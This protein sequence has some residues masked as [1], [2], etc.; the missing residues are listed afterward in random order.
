MELDDGA[1][2]AALSASLCEC[3]EVNIVAKIF[4]HLINNILQENKGD[5]SLEG[6]YTP[7]LQTM[8]TVIERFCGIFSTSEFSTLVEEYMS[9]DDRGTI[10]T[11]T[12]P[13]SRKRQDPTKRHAPTSRGVADPENIAAALYELIQLSRD[14]GGT[15]QVQLVGGANAVAVAAIGVWLVDLP[16]SF[17]KAGQGL[18]EVIHTTC[19][20]DQEPRVKV[21]FS[22]TVPDTV[23]LTKARVVYLYH[24]THILQTK[25]LNPDLV[26]GGRCKWENVFSGTFPGSFQRLMK[27]HSNFGP[28]LGSAARVF[29][30]LAEGDAE[31]PEDWHAACRTYFKSSFGLDYVA[32]ALW[33]FPELNKP[34]QMGESMRSYAELPSYSE[35]EREFEK[36]MTAIAEECH[37]KY[38]CFNGTP[39]A[40]RNGAP[41]TNFK[42]PKES[43]CLTALAS[44]IIRLVRVL[45]G[46]ELQHKSLYPTRAGVECFFNQ[47]KSRLMRQRGAA[48]ETKTVKDELFLYR[49][50]EYV[51]FT[52]IA[53]EYSPLAMAHMI[54][55]GRQLN[56]D[57]RPYSSAISSDGICC[58]YKILVEPSRDPAISAQV[59]V[60]PGWIQYRDVPYS[61]VGD[62]GWNPF[63]DVAP[64]KIENRP[65]FCV[66]EKTRRLAQSCLN[67]KLNL[68]INE[69]LVEERNPWLE[70]GF[71]V[72]GKE[73]LLSHLGPAKA[74]ENLTRGTGL[75]SCQGLQYHATDNVA[76]AIARLLPQGSPSEPFVEV[77][78]GNSNIF[79]FRGDLSTAL[80]VACGSWRPLFLTE[81]TCL[82]CGVR[83]GIARSWPN[84]AIVCSEESYKRAWVTTD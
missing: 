24:M 83:T 58:F 19:K 6:I 49:V 54:F 18:L 2:F 25:E 81:L 74:V 9:L 53:P 60:L 82:A 13:K 12:L 61:G 68:L 57:I 15:R 10:T 72:L 77:E 1:C 56:E 64:L 51:K 71:E 62:L 20:S 66:P 45:S 59:C 65:T 34:S 21:I 3:Y 22:E 80:I 8:R 28:A 44:A 7:S 50:L 33:W 48:K 63:K 69:R 38:C 39:T 75:I 84:F 16:T 41:P 30:A 29:K 35:A 79:I 23:G 36:S 31:L 46:V 4:L 78:Y 52:K 42:E 40:K 17:Y 26:L 5:S 70:V 55:S 73:G 14:N 32:F 27:M 11:Y 76:E 67:N 43:Y 47:Q 37:C